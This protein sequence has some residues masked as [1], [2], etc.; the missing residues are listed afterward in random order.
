[1]QFWRRADWIPT[2]KPASEITWAGFLISG[3]VTPLSEIDREGGIL[4]GSFSGNVTIPIPPCGHKYVIHSPSSGRI[5][6]RDAKDLD[7]HPLPC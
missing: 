2:L 7:G 3:L 1:M 6:F 5:E 4:A